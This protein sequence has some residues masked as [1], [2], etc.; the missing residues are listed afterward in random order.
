M[1]QEYPEC[2]VL[3]VQESPAALVCVLSHID[4]M[5]TI[6]PTLT[7]FP[8]KSSL[9]VTPTHAV[10]ENAVNKM[11]PVSQP[12]VVVRQMLNKKELQLQERRHAS[13]SKLPELSEWQTNQ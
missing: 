2:C 1:N 11:K 6:L 12:L 10:T 13:R 5:A 8:D 3:V 7:S 4:D 9:K